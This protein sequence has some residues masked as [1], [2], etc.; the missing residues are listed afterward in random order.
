MPALR[1]EQTFGSTP[2]WP[3]GGG[4]CGTLI[5]NHDWSATPL[6]PVAD[7]SGALRT[8]VAN[9]V[10]SPVPKVLM[11]GPANVLI[12]ND[13]YTAIAGDKHPAALGG[14]AEG[15]WPEIW[16]WNR[17]ILA[18][19][20]T[21]EVVA[22]R[23]QPMT[24]LRDGVPQTFFLDLFYTPVYL[25][26]GT[27]GGV[28][29]TAIDN[30][31]RIG[32]E[33]AVAHSAAELRSI[34]DALP[35]LI[36]YIDRDL[37]YRFA[38]NAYQDWFG[39]AP[40]DVVGRHLREVIGEVSYAERL[41]LIQRALAGEPIRSEGR[42]SHRDGSF[43]GVDIRY[44]PR[45]DE[46]GE[47]LG[48]HVLANDIEER[49][50]REAAV[51]RSNE[52]FRGAMEAVHGVLWTNSRDGQMTGE[53]PGWAALT[54]QSREDYAGY[55]WANAVHPEDADATVAAWNA[56]V[57]TKSVFVFEHRVR[58]HDGAW[59]N[60]LIRAQP[61]TD[62]DGEIVEWVGVHTDITEQRAAEQSL[63]DQAEHL[64]RQVRH[65]ER[66][67][68]QLRHLNEHL[69][70]R[71]ISEIGERRRAEAALAQAQK[72]ET[73]GKLTGGVAHDFNNLLQVV[74]GN[75][76]LLAKDIAGN[77]RAERRV[78]NAMAGVSRGSKLAAQLLAFGRRQALEPK[79]VNVTRFVQ[80]MDDM[81]R[82]AI[83]EGVEVETVFGGG[84]WNCFIDPAQ[85]ENALLNLA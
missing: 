68:E 17:A 51:R 10:N 5:R 13:A 84:L 8:T 73:I 61:I 64:Q 49:A 41:P 32:A 23:D 1:P 37:T 9:I 38:N 31:A 59:R 42:L 43:H 11:W 52:R 56:A 46:K 12:Y 54:G 72:M 14:T 39:R 28:M 19:G 67:E 66:A 78:A 71:V 33:A 40:E 24:L 55:G 74:S 70:A 82:R 27:V 60:C 15:V 79:V 35:V 80:G 6:G 22:Y 16:E 75:L 50:Q 83:G 69:E 47:V 18:R 57:A 2:Q 65:R 76:Q 29:C 77:D 20:A 48:I 85:I 63:R 25:D 30:T 81:L 26:D 58:R 53:Q 45:F 36:S 3:L 44:L 7:W 21:G 62:A 34:T 4:G